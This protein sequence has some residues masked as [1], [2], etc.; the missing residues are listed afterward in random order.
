MA[1]TFDWTVSS[2]ATFSSSPVPNL[3]SGSSKLRIPAGTLSPGTTY[4]VRLVVTL[5]GAGSSSEIRTLVVERSPLTARISSGASVVASLSSPLAL[6][7]SRSFDPDTCK[8]AIP[9]ELQPPCSDPLLTYVWS[10]TWPSTGDVCR[11]SSDDRILPLGDGPKVAIDLPSLARGYGDVQQHS[12]IAITVNVIKGTRSASATIRVQLTNDR[13]LQMSIDVLKSSSERLLLRASPSPSSQNAKCTW[14][15]SGWTLPQNFAYNAFPFNDLE[16]VSTGWEAPT[17]SMLLRVP[18][19]TTVLFPGSTY[20]VML[21]CTTPEGIRG[22]A[23]H[24]W[25]MGIPPWGGKCSTTP[26]V[27]E[28][29]STFTVTC[30][31]WSA[32]ELPLQ[33]AF[34][35][36]APGAELSWSLP[37]FASVATFRLPENNYT[38]VARVYDAS[39]I[40][41]LSSPEHVMVTAITGQRP[42]QSAED[43]MDACIQDLAD[44]GQSSALM[45]L[46]DN[47]IDTAMEGVSS[48]LSPRGL[49]R[50]LASTAAYR[51]RVRRLLL[52]TFSQGSVAR[53]MA[54]ENAPRALKSVS[55][56]SRAPPQENL[57]LDAAESSLSLFVSGSALA[58]SDHLRSG[59]LVDV[60]SLADSTVTA[61]EY[62]PSRAARDK[63]LLGCK[64]S[65]QNSAQVYLRSMTPDEAPVSVTKPGLG[66]VFTRQ[67]ASTRHFSLPSFYGSSVAYSLG[68]STSSTRQ[69]A[70][71]T[72]QTLPTAAGDDDDYGPGVYVTYWPKPWRAANATRDMSDVIGVGLAQGPV[73]APPLP[74]ALQLHVS[75]A[76]TSTG[77]VR[78]WLR[79][80]VPQ[81]AVV[82]LN[83]NSTPQDIA[84]FSQTLRCL[85]W[86]HQEQWETDTCALT[87]VSF[88][89]PNSSSSGRL[90]VLCTCQEDGFFYADWAPPVFPPYH[91][92]RGTLLVRFIAWWPGLTYLCAVGAFLVVMSVLAFVAARH[93]LLH[94]SG[95]LGVLDAMPAALW[96]ADARVRSMEGFWVSVLKPEYVKE[97]LEG[98]MGDMD[99]PLLKAEFGVVTINQAGK[100][101]WEAQSLGSNVR[102]TPSA[103]VEQMVKDLMNQRKHH[104]A[105]NHTE[106]YGAILRNKSVE[107]QGHDPWR[108]QARAG[109]SASSESPAR[110]ALIQMVAASS[111]PSPKLA[112]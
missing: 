73:L 10:C 67:H 33:Y 23:S 71:A 59:G 92:L 74:P 45:M 94:M 50:L 53:E 31:T 26:Q 29:F 58:L 35:T 14:A 39:G 2:S 93:A 110:S 57:P 51:S 19:A 80:D 4:Y 15:I 102:R 60:T 109:A 89:P 87:N 24:T 88:V 98:E 28:A 68:A 112:R 69:Q 44:L 62:M 17:F 22:V 38:S 95:R 16:F 81:A 99:E 56:L 103:Y 5:P 72:Q 55:K 37:A 12:T 91:T 108:D 107:S 13:V 1:L 75:K 7:A 46:A 42:G 84:Y 79:M 6:D 20:T 105:E 78:V 70:E 104:H 54:A 30:S 27:A 8:P 101:F 86:G 66:L 83:N 32:E 18:P 61:A 65:I 97:L 48:F 77:C 36:G 96:V 3:I 9:G 34:G 63:L 25:R 49:R 100:A 40:W 11:R 52:N 85:H 47:I 43:V 111:R 82:V 41:S 21:T 76:C 90:R 64:E 106:A